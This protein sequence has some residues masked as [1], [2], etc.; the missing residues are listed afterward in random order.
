MRNYLTYV[1]LLSWLC[2]ILLTTTTTA[3]DKPGQ[4]WPYNNFTEGMTFAARK[5]K[6]TE[7]K[8]T[9][10]NFLTAS[11]SLMNLT[12]IALANNLGNMFENTFNVSSDASN[13][14]IELVPR[15]N[16]VVVTCDLVVA[17]F[18]SESSRIRKGFL[19][20]SGHAEA[21][22]HNMSL[23][24][25][26]IWTSIPAADFNTTGRRLM[27]IKCAYAVIRI[28]RRALEFKFE[29]NLLSRVASI[30]H[31]SVLPVVTGTVE[32]ALART[33][34]NEVPTVINALF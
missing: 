21:L 25:E 18:I 30:F 32:E 33:I 8:N 27:G 6:W 24:N 12:S 2:I 29:G 17:I 4:E 22:N 23:N 16:G 7:F 26:L 9:N 5:D 34:N 28:D 15:D 1:L 11:V 19:T 3:Q 14:A 31:D 10:W 13:A 20:L